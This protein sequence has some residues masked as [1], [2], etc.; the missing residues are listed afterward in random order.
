M[1][2]KK[3]AAPGEVNVEVHLWT[4][5]KPD[6]SARESYADNLKDANDEALRTVAAGI[7]G[8]LTGA[9]AP[10]PP[11]PP[12]PSPPAPVAGAQKAAPNMAEGGLQAL[13][14]AVAPGAAAPP[15][16]EAETDR[17]Q[18]RTVLAYSALAVG[19][20]AIVV[21]GI[22][23]GNWVS[24]N[25]KSS[26]DRKQVPSTVTDVCV[27]PVNLYAQDACNRSKD[28]VTSSTLAWVF[29]GIGATLVGTG[30]VLILTESNAP[31]EERSDHRARLLPRL[32]P[33][34]GGVDLHVQF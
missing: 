6:T 14:V 9:T 15:A 12:Q 34:S 11:P 22:E 23:V 2:D 17:F 5:G 28:A 4:R 18:T 27:Q 13:S 26:D 1:L 8:K 25:N 7:F 16:E 32:G 29:G 30:I 20:A 19:A 33:G 21:A 10:P 24:D 31:P 3:K